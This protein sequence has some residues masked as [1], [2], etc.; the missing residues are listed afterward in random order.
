MASPFPMARD[1]SARATTATGR[2]EIRAEESAGRGRA[3]K[4][5]KKSS[6]VFSPRLHQPRRDATTAA[7]KLLRLT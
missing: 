3:K 1:E 2:G 6:H 5:E 7:S 4:T